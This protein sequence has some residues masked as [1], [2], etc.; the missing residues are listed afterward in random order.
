MKMRTQ[1][2]KSQEFEDTNGIVVTNFSAAGALGTSDVIIP[3]QKAAKT[4][5]DAAIAGGTKPEGNVTVLLS[6]ETGEICSPKIYFPMKV[7]VN[8]INTIV[9]KVFEATNAGTVQ[10][11]N[12]VGDSA[13]GLTILQSTDA[14]GTRYVVN[15]T[16][17]NV[18]AADSFYQLKC[19][20]V[21][22]GGKVYATIG[23]TL[24]A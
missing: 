5:A 3:T 6:F 22:A 8:S 14:L 18:V 2:I 15:P 17:N 10:G 11:A 1:R 12:S 9:A 7:T 19:A 23:Y 13:T 20:K 16:T 21:T 4:Y 24:T